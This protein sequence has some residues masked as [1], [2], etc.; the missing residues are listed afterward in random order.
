M[1]TKLR[2]H[3]FTLIELLVVIAIIS[4][5]AAILFPVFARARENARRSSCQSNLKQIALG[6]MQYTQDNDERLPQAFNVYGVTSVRPFGWADAIQPYLKSAQILQCPSESTAAT[7]DAGGQPNPT[8]TGY[9]DYSFNMRLFTDNGGSTGTYNSVSLAALTQPTLT[10]M[11]LD[12]NAAN[13]TGYGWGCGQGAACSPFPAGLARTSVAAA[14]RHL[15]GANI[16]F[17]DGHVKW[18]KSAGEDSAYFAN[19]YNSKTLIATS[20]NNPTFNPSP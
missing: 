10:I 1:F 14:N 2:K 20:G 16:A 15:G 6:I 9:T 7:L 5:L 12:D 11:N 13:A 17:T 19:V 18:Y 3:A 4:I 8:Q